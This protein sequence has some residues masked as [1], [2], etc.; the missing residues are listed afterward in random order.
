MVESC[1]FCRKALPETKKEVDKLKMKRI[2]ANDPAALFHEGVEQAQKRN[3]PK[4]LSNWEMLMRTINLASCCIGRD[5]VEKD[6]K[7]VCIIWKK[8]LFVVTPPQDGNLD[9]SR[10]RMETV[11]DQ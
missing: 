3:T 2:E 8:Q 1:P 9:L 10:R 5:L 7:K 4:H 6:K 11:R